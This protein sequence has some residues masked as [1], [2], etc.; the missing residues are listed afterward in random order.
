MTYA[1][2][3]LLFPVNVCNLIAEGFAS[4]SPPC[5]AKRGFDY[6]LGVVQREKFVDQVAG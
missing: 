4:Y 5:R 3:L 1:A 6:N 2:T